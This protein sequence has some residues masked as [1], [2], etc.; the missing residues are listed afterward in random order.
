MAISDEELVT[1]LNKAA[2]LLLHI[3]AGAFRF[4]AA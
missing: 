1:K 4:C 3:K 2:L